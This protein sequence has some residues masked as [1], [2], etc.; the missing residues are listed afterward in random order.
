MPE[1]S[2]VF[3]AYLESLKKQEKNKKTAQREGKLSVAT[4]ETLEEENSGLDSFEPKKSF[5]DD[6]EEAVA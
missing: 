1:R 3:E 5:D 2:P 6:H 4:D